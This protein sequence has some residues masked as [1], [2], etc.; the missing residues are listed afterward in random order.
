MDSGRLT[1]NNVPL[2]PG[3]R[4]LPFARRFLRKRVAA[5]RVDM[6]RTGNFARR[7]PFLRR[8]ANFSAVW[9]YADA[10]A[11]ADNSQTTNSKQ[12]SS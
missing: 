9:V 2:G 12:C 3:G 4:L 7:P 10:I 6:G 11:I 8:G 5:G 1:M